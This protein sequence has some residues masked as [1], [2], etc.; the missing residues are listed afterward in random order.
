MGGWCM[1]CIEKNVTFRTL[2][3]E[4]VTWEVFLDIVLKDVMPWYFI[5]MGQ[6]IHTVK[7]PVIEVSHYVPGIFPTI[8]NKYLS[9]RNCKYSTKCDILHWIIQS[10]TA[11]LTRN[12]QRSITYHYSI[13]QQQCCEYDDS[14]SEIF[15]CLVFF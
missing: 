4:Q 15:V 6:P 8:H 7:K 1:C 13:S 3:T 2:E 12:W 10:S 14:K 5:K 9:K 11:L